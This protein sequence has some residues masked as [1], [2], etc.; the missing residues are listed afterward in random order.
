M[1]GEPNQTSTNQGKYYGEHIG[2]V[3]CIDDPNHL[4]R[5]QVRVFSIHTEQV[6]MKA[7]P[8]AEYKLPLGARVNDGFFTPV[9]LGDYVWVDFPYNTDPRRPRITGSVHMAP[10]KVPNFPH[11]AFAGASKL[12]HKTTG[13]EP[14]PAAATYHRNCVYTQHG[15]TIEINEDTS[16]AVTQRASG[17]AIRISPQGD[18]TLHSEKKIF[19][20]AKEAALIT[21]PQLALNGEQSVTISAPVVNINAGAL[22]MGGGGATAVLTGNFEIVGP[23]DVKGNI[24]A[25]GNIIDGGSNTNHHSH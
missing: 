14:A 21:A 17:T 16:F 2:R 1:N 9:D 3:E 11:E 6:P 4:M 18:I 13:E 15:V 5:V 24:S 23:I 20:S 10:G 8:W 12:V 22:G 7:L 19:A 25:T